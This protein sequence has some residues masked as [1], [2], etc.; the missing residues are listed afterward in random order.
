MI[1][2]GVAVSLG[3]FPEVSSD[4]LQNFSNLNCTKVPTE[5]Y[6]LYAGLLDM[7]VDMVDKV[8]DEEVK[9]EKIVKGI[10]KK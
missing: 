8:A 4:P 7:V 5:S 1:I 10:E 2:H 6:D 9:G 3:V